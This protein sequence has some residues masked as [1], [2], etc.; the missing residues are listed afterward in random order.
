[1]K[2]TY[3]I[4]VAISPDDAIRS[5]MLKQIIVD[6]GFAQI[7]SDAAKLIQKT[8]YDIDY[9]NAFFVF[10]D[11][12]NVRESIITTQKLYEMAAKGFC[13]VIGAKKLSPEHEF[14]CNVYYPS[15]FTRL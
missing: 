3:K 2:K 5:S 12:Y 10:A 11:I 9:A 15:D 7:P 8:P 13:V 6:M 4:H 1:M 14:I